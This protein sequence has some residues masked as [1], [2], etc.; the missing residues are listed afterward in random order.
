MTSWSHKLQYQ[1]SWPPRLR[2]GTIHSDSHGFGWGPRSPVLANIYAPR[3]HKHNS[4]HA[5]RLGSQRRRSHACVAVIRTAKIAHTTCQKW[6]TVA[7]SQD[8]VRCH[9]GERIKSTYSV[10]SCDK[11][12]KPSSRMRFY[13]YPWN[14]EETTNNATNYLCQVFEQHNAHRHKACTVVDTL[15]I[16]KVIRHRLPWPWAVATGHHHQ[17][18]RAGMPC[19]AYLHLRRSCQEPCPS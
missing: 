12:R 15:K 11:I 1:Q 13:K 14:D 7:T 10:G 9:A 8:H 5:A 17:R 18:G 6:C 4:A 16:V 19:H 3:K 2:A